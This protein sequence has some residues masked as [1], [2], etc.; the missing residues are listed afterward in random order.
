ME[1]I[2]TLNQDL[3]T[4]DI[5]LQNMQIGVPLY[6]V[7]MELRTKEVCLEAVKYN[8]RNIIYVPAD[9]MTEEMVYAAY[10][11][12]VLCRN[13]LTLIP[14]KFK[15][16]EFYI[17][18]IDNIETVGDIRTLLLNI[19]KARRT[20]EVCLAAVKKCGMA[21]LHVPKKFKTETLCMYAVASN[22]LAIQYIENPTL[23]MCRLALRSNTN[24]KKYIDK[25]VLKTLSGGKAV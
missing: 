7:K 2:K 12:V 15:T 25:E 14:E 16:D 6:Y 13:C 24:A 1:T 8:I 10:N 17:Y 4:I 22:G 19:P 9:V 3:Q 23:K 11:Y 21:L 20:Y 5:C 18:A